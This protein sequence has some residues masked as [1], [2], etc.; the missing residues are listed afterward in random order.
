MTRIM[1]DSIQALITLMT[2]TIL[3]ELFSHMKATIKEIPNRV[4]MS[5]KCYTSLLLG[6]FDGIQPSILC[7]V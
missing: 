2:T 3:N 1:Q 5:P 4:V 6:W 7:H